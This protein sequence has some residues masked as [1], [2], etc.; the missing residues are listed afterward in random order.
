MGSFFSIFVQWYIYRVIKMTWD[1]LI[2]YFC[3]RSSCCKEGPECT[4]FRNLNV[5]I[6][7]CEQYEYM[8]IS[9][10][11]PYENHIPAFEKQSWS[12]LYGSWIYN[13]LCHQC[14]S[15]PNVVNSNPAHGE[16]YLMQH[17][18]IKFVSDLGQDGGFLCVLWFPPPIKLTTTIYLKHCWK[19]R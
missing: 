19:C 3:I 7:I 6:T 13:Y 8:C 15:P 5:L 14:L 11:P 9:Y 2:G 10:I 1:T 4:S 17:Y 12:W 16:V 18:V